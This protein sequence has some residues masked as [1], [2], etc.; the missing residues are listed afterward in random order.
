ML[1]CIL[2]VVAFQCMV[3]NTGRVISLA[4]FGL[5][6]VGQIGTSAFSLFNIPDGILGRQQMAS[7]HYKVGRTKSS[8][9]SL[10]EQTG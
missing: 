1:S 4:L 5:E 7:L 8:G 9:E 6:P 10:Y 2:D 3:S